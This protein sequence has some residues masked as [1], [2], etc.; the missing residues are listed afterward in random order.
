MN[1]IIL[2]ASIRNG[3]RSDRVA[4]FFKRYISEQNIGNPEILD[5]KDYN[6]PL[7]EERL[8][9]L[10]EYPEGL[11]EFAN[12]IKNAGGIII[13]TPEYNGGYPAS[14]KNV[15]DVLYEEWQGKPVGIASVSNGLL[16]GAQVV[17][18]LQF[19]LWKMG[20]N[21][22]PAMFPVRKVEESFAKDGT[23]SDKEGTGKAAEK[24][25]GYFK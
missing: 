10:K 22:V 17:T 15:V 3:R 21:V 18:S 12:R 24:F 8:K 25:L 20:V 4:E 23:P 11:K 13:V 7:F 1:I 2:L 5:L 19:T 6:F 14:L 9:F 16:G